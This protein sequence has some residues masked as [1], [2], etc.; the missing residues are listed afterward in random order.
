MERM[1]RMLGEKSKIGV[2]T[3]VDGNNYG[4][5]LQNYALN[6]TLKGLGYDV[7]TIDRIT[8]RTHSTVKKA[9]LFYGRVLLKDCI[10]QGNM[11]GLAQ[12]KRQKAFDRFRKNYIAYSDFRVGFN[13]FPKERTGDYRFF[14][15]GSDQIWNMNY[16]IIREDKDTF[17]GKFAEK[18]KKIAYAASFGADD[19]PEEYEEYIADALK[20]FKAVSV[21]ETA[22][23]KISSRLGKE[24]KL[25]P[26]PTLL[27][28]QNDWLKVA[29]KPGKLDK[30]EYVLTYFLGKVEAHILSDI[31][32]Y[33]KS[34]GLRV[35]NL[36]DRFDRSFCKRDADFFSVDPNEFV[37]LVCNCKCFITDSF[38]GTVFSLIFGRPFQVLDRATSEKNNNLN[39]RIKTILDYFGESKRFLSEKTD[40]NLL[41][42]EPNQ[43]LIEKKRQEFAKTGVEFLVNELEN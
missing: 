42:A 7:E 28:S 32:E 34:R 3:I 20:D 10:M 29:K 30:E 15:F 11:K 35:I 26:D 22:G 17:C 18:E 12:L 9:V 19:V 40:L 39:S 37:W 27:L 13:N 5:L 16:R 6:E 1:D 33:A 4:N 43:E 24:C 31:D 38:H 23:L 41:A 25:V 36:R 14:V 2:V 21:R 8:F